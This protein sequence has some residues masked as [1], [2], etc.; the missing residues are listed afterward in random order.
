MNVSDCFVTCVVAPRITTSMFAIQLQYPLETNREVGRRNCTHCKLLELEHASRNAPT[1]AA[2]RPTDHRL[3]K[4]RI[5][6]AHA[7][8]TRRR[9]LI[10]GGIY[11]PYELAKE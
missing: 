4:V 7:T 1:T 6:P 11:Y 9:K 5:Y 3:G 2:D 8:H 10:T